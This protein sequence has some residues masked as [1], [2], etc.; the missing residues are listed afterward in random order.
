ML[1]VELFPSQNYLVVIVGLESYVTL[2]KKISSQGPFPFHVQQNSQREFLTSQR[3]VNSIA[4]LVPQIPFCSRLGFI[5]GQ[6]FSSTRVISSLLAVGTLAN[7]YP[8]GAL[9]AWGSCFL[10]QKF[11]I[12]RDSVV[13]KYYSSLVLLVR[14]RLHKSKV[15]YMPQSF[16][17]LVLTAWL[18]GVGQTLF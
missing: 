6:A 7:F 18:C 4:P 2:V 16:S 11:S 1:G 14:K 9:G 15:V 12:L 10:S 3:W 17:S 5:L 13:Q 8:D